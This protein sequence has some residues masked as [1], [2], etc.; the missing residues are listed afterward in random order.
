VASARGDSGQEVIAVLLNSPDR[1]EE[2]K[3]ALD[4]ALKAYSWVEAL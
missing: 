2:G 1:F 4:W 3:K